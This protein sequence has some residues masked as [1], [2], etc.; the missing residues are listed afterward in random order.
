MTRRLMAPIPV[1]SNAWTPRDDYHA[2]IAVENA[3]YDGTITSEG[4]TQLGFLATYSGTNLKPAVTRTTK[5]QLPRRS[6]NIS[7]INSKG[8]WNSRTRRR[9]CGVAGDR[10]AESVAQLQAAEA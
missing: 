7:I 10:V 3:S 6:G 1:S 4:N 5:Q 2:V 8:C 9:R